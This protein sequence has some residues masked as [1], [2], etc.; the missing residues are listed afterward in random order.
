[1]DCRV[2]YFV[3]TFIVSS[4]PYSRDTFVSKRKDPTDCIRH[5]RGMVFHP[6]YLVPEHHQATSS[7]SRSPCDTGAT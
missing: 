5:S 7:A 3:A 6:C 2:H 1:M 4:V